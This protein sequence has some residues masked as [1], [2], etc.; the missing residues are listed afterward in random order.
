MSMALR[1]RFPLTDGASDYLGTEFKVSA[2]NAHV[3]QEAHVAKF[4]T[5]AGYG[6]RRPMATPLTTDDTAADFDASKGTDPNTANTLE[7][8]H[9]SEQLGYSATHTMPWL[10]YASGVFSST[11]R[12]SPFR[13]HPCQDTALLWDARS[14]TL[15]AR[16]DTDSRTHHRARV[17]PSHATAAHHTIERCT[18]PHQ[19]SASSIRRMHRY[20]RRFYPRVLSGTTVNSTFD[21]RV[22]AYSAR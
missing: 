18:G 3:H 4:F 12:P 8:P 11:S 7:F 1:N 9:V 10:L 5:E 21:I 16:D 2:N 15:S 14:D 6:G 17:P 19:D 13:V 20:I 22:R